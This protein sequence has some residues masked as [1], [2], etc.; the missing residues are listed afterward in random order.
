MVLVVLV[1]FGL[2]FHIFGTIY[3]PLFFASEPSRSE[4]K[5][6]LGQV[7]GFF[8]VGFHLSMACLHVCLS[9]GFRPRSELWVLGFRLPYRSAA[10]AS[11]RIW[12]RI[13]I[14]IR[15]TGTWPPLSFE[16][17]RGWPGQ[18]LK[19]LARLQVSF[20]PLGSEF[21]LRVELRRFFA[22][23][24]SFTPLNSWNLFIGKNPRTMEKF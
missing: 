8:F 16:H 19:C 9:I 2:K 21:L 12:I 10:I 18:M 20:V 6:V 4:Q 24:Q 3:G 17:A 14:R 23:L 11:A 15:I 22:C 7:E 13:W 5:R 1:T